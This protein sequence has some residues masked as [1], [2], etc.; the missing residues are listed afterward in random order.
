M[1]TYMKVGEL[2]HCVASRDGN[3]EIIPYA[4]L[5]YDIHEELGAIT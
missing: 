2:N 1:L 4:T 5:I 3:R